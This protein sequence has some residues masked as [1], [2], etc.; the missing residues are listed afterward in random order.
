M[1][2][3]IS[4]KHKEIRLFEILIKFKFNIFNHF[5]LGKEKTVLIIHDVQPAQLNVKQTEMESFKR[6]QPTAFDTAG[7]VIFCG[8]L[9]DGFC[10]DG[11]DW[12]KLVTLV[13]TVTP[14]GAHGPGTA[15][16]ITNVSLS[17]R[18]F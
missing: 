11:E 7:L 12:N 16:F 15:H 5:I 17:P 8:N 4:C 14:K 13:A 9:K 2:Y 18:E 1:I 10:V 6:N 3:E